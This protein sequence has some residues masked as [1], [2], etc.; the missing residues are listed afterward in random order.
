MIKTLIWS[1]FSIFKLRMKKSIKV[2][3]AQLESLSEELFVEADLLDYLLACRTKQRLKPGIWFNIFRFFY[4]SFLSDC[5]DLKPNDSKHKHT[6]LS[7]IIWKYYRHIL[8]ECSA[9]AYTN[10]SRSDLKINPRIWRMTYILIVSIMYT[11]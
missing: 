5:T 7:Q 11:I 8:A 10:L 4:T 1:S 6:C 2:N 9:H 3:D